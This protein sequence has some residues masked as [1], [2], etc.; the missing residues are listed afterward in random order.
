M[1]L[2]EMTKAQLIEK[3]EE[4]STSLDLNIC[5][6]NELGAKVLELEKIEN[7]LRA[8]NDSLKKEN[9]DLKG[10]AENYRRWWQ[11]ESDKL[12]KVKDSLAAASVVL[13][14]IANEATK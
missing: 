1:E 7:E 14:A 5:R 10:S 3:V 2:Q 9:I 11:S 12:A 4:L 13:R 8:E 6:N